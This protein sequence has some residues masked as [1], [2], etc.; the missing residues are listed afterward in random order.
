MSGIDATTAATATA[1][2][3]T[4][5]TCANQHVI[6]PFTPVFPPISNTLKTAAAAPS[7][8]IGTLTT[9]T[10][11]LTSLTVDSSFSCQGVASLALKYFTTSMDRAAG[12]MGAIVGLAV[13]VGLASWWWAKVVQ[14]PSPKSTDG[15]GV[16]EKHLG[17]EAEEIEV[18]D[19]VEVAERR[20]DVLVEE[21]FTFSTVSPDS[22]SRVRAATELSLGST[23]SVRTA[24]VRTATERSLGSMMSVRTATERR[25]DVVVERQDR[26]NQARLALVIVTQLMASILLLTG[27]NG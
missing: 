3:T 20:S 27:P 23:S 10:R 6:R 14:Q 5:S 2:T 9:A 18:E 15:H 24:R 26:C 4:A 17:I 19:E 25:A 7:T 16:S 13:V 22:T 1:A 12:V 21:P 11:Y 8:P